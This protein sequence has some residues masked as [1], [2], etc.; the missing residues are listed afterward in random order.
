ML[1]LINAELY[2]LKKSKTFK[3]CIII[4]IIFSAILASKFVQQAP[5]IEDFFEDNAL[6]DFL[7]SLTSEENATTFNLIGVGTGWNAL[8]MNTENAI[9]YMITSIGLGTPLSLI[10]AIF[11]PIFITTEYSNGTIKNIIT[12]GYKRRTIYFSK[13]IISCIV[14]ILFLYVFLIASF[15]NAYINYGLGDINTKML[16]IIFIFFI[17]QSFTHICIAAV[18]TM[19]S[20]TFKNVIASLAGCLFIL[21]LITSILQF[22]D[23]FTSFKLYNY[24]ISYPSSIFNSLESVG[25]NLIRGG[26]IVFFYFIISTIIGVHIFKKCDIR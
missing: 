21:P 2:K 25:V 10:F 14:S 3:V 16:S 26:L 4:L 11:I 5:H 19:F 22:S 17:Y 23:M 8:I 20:M 13:L 12:K 24:W 9:S 15:I 6:S 1:N 18:F 7:Y